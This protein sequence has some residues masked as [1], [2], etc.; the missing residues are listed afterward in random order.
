MNDQLDEQLHAGFYFYIFTSKTTFVSNSLFV[1]PLVMVLLGYFFP[2]L[3]ALTDKIYND[4]EYQGDQQSFKSAMVFALMTYGLGCFYLQVPSLYMEY[5][6][7]TNKRNQVC[8]GSREI[9]EE[10]ARFTLMTIGIISIGYLILFK[11]FQG[12]H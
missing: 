6:G 7:I 9:K 4:K 11:L 1:Y 5:I 8:L 2:A 10:I 3:I 12:K